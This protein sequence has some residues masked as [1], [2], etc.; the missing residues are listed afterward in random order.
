MFN[1]RCLCGGYGHSVSWANPI[2]AKRYFWLG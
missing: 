1:A 2:P